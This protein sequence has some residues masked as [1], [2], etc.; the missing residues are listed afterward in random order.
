MI[1]RAVAVILSLCILGLVVPITLATTVRVEPAYQLVTLGDEFTVNIT[2]DPEGTEIYAADYALHF[3]NLVLQAVSQTKGP[4]LGGD[5]L[6]ISNQLNNAQG[7]IDYGES[8]KSPETTGVTNPGVLTTVKF[9][10]RCSGMSE[11]RFDAV[12]LSDP[13]ASK[14]DD[15]NTTNGTVETTNSQPAQPFLV[16]G[17]VFYHNGGPCDNPLVTI[18]N[19]NTSEE[20]S[21]ETTESANYYQLTLTSPYNVTAGEV[22][23]LN[24]TSPDSLQS[25]TTSR[26]V[27]AEDITN[28]GLFNVNLTLESADLPDLFITDF[29]VCW[30]DNC[31]ICYSIAN[32]G[33]ATAS[34]GHTTALLV[35]GIERATDGVLVPLEPHTSY[36]SCFESYTWVYS[37]PDDNLTV[38]ADS[39]AVVTESGE[40]N[41]CRTEHWRCGDVN[42]DRVVDTTDVIAVWDYFT[43][44]KPM[45]NKWAADAAPA[46]GVID[47]T[48]VLA[49]WNNFVS[50]SPLSCSCSS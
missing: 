22:V 17:Y 16:Y 39:D 19:L 30:P 20:W 35:D 43:I 9:E 31:T 45:A 32:T 11:L 34:A 37:A 14:V 4:F 50:G 48:D 2:V 7:I 12:T 38:C 49:I 3:N 44:G 46:N 8:R 18:T 24:A 10:V 23:Q 6:I 28:G 27:S 21:A 15:V 42:E 13:T 47:T 36:T 40:E 41:N 1:P 29:W 5:T 26:E 33:N 25:N